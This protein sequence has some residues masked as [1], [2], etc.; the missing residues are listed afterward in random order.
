MNRLDNLPDD[1]VDKIYEEKHK[2]EM[3][4]VFRQM[5]ET[6]FDTLNIKGNRKVLR[7]TYITESV[8]KLP[9]GVDLENKNQV[10]FW[11]VKWDTLY[12]KYVNGRK[13]EINPYFGA[14]EIDMKYPNDEEFVDENEYH[15]PF[16]THCPIYSEDED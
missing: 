3:K 12:I 16:D 9:D 14:A 8:F 10:E 15:L 2:M 6:K 7:A 1:I 5:M 11:G 13:E 4:L